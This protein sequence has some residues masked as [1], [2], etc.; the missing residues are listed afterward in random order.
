MVY[1]NIMDF[2]RGSIVCW[3]EMVW[4]MATLLQYLPAYMMPT[5]QNFIMLGATYRDK[6]REIGFSTIA[7]KIKNFMCQVGLALNV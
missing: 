1:N 6:Y 7:K 2:C 3:I 4:G 5:M